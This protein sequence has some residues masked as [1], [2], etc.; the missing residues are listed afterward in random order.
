SYEDMRKYGID[1]TSYR[2]PTNVTRTQQKRRELFEKHGSPSAQSVFWQQVAPTNYLN[3]IKGAIALHH[4]VDD[5]VVNI[6]YS[7][8]LTALLDKTSVEH[9]LIEHP[10][11]GHNISGNA[12]VS[13]MQQTVDFFRKHLQVSSQ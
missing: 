1:D 10:S 11:G 8:D 5:D 12:F 9:E 13:A 6:G 3:D 7:R 2:P 4:A